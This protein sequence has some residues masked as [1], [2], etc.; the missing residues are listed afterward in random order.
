MKYFT[1]LLVV[2]AFSTTSYSQWQIQNS[3]T[4]ENLND[5]TIAPYTSGNSYLLLGIMGQF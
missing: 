4:T 5:V 3:G 1:L 2:L